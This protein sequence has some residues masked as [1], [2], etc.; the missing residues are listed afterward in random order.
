[1]TRTRVGEG[2]DLARLSARLG[3]PGCMILRAN[4]LMSPAW[5]LPGREIEAPDPDYCENAPPG[6]PCPR[7]AVNSPALGQAGTGRLLYL[8]GPETAASLRGR[9]GPGEA[10]RCV[11]LEEGPLAAGELIFWKEK[12]NG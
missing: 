4:G 5:L 9:L 8:T 2:E 1:M 7:R 10:L 12:E 3:A 6:K 11:P